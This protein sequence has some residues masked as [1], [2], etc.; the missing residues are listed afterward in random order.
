[1]KEYPYKSIFTSLAVKCVTDKEK[2]E[3]L[4]LASLEQLKSFIPE[5]G[6]T[7]GSFLPI[8]FNAFT[9][10]RVNKND[11]VIDTKTTLAIYKK[12]VN[13]PI[14]IEHKRGNVVGFI[15]SAGFSE[16]GTDKPLTEDEVKDYKKPFNVVLGGVI[17]K[18]VNNELAD[19]IQDSND[20]TSENY[21]NISAS[22]ELGFTGYNL[23]L[24]D[25]GQKNT[26]SG[27]IIAEGSEV[28][29]YK[30]KLRAMGGEGMVDEKRLY[31]MPSEEVEPLG[32]G[33]TEKPAGDVKGVAVKAKEIKANLVILCSVCREVIS[34]TPSSGKETIGSS[35]TC[36][37]KC[38]EKQNNISQLEKP[39]VNKNKIM[40]F[41]SISDITDESLKECKAS[42]ITD[43][44]ST[45]IKEKSAEYEKD[46]KA[47]DTKASEAKALAEKN[48]EE[49]VK[50]NTELEK[51]N[52]ALATLEKEKQDREAV[53]KFNERMAKLSEEYDFDDEARAAI[54]DD[55][56]ALDSDEAFAKWEKKSAAIFKP[57]KK[58]F[59]KGDEKKEKTDKEKADEAKAALDAALDKGQKDK[60]DL[61]NSA[62][63]ASK[64]TKEKY[65]SAFARDQFVVTIK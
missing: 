6:S 19:L 15:L 51:V 14:N 27:Q 12:F 24:L 1:M 62:D 34:E 8:A 26:E 50:S 48:A 9:P 65:A 45:Q 47:L 11:D 55:V 25:K 18:V 56:K 22:W 64:T 2:D 28:E 44:I 10:N 7:N 52:K 33:L 13:T 32:I 42:A 5:A 53:D 4:A 59:K 40:K 23:L 41:N 60:K 49:L 17:W 39:I 37:D 43:F 61:P 31:R 3:L 54:I 20:P 58:G 46:K 30:E 29:K 38:I 35:E 57:F 63:S 16:F 36:C 21:M